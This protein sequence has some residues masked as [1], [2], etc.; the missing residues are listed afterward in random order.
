MKASQFFILL[1]FPLQIAF[2]QNLKPYTLALESSVSIS[3]LKVQIEANLELNGIQV[4]GQYQPADDSSRWVIV[5][6]SQEL[7]SAV[8]EVGGRTGFGAALRLGITVENGKTIVSYTN[9]EYWGKAYFR[10]EFEKVSVNYSTLSDNLQRAMEATG[11][12]VGTYFGSKKGLSTKELTKY[13]Y[14]L[15]MPRFG[16]SVRLEEFGSHQ[17]AIDKIESAIESGVP[18]VELVY[19]LDIPDQDLILYGFALSGDKG[20]GRFL[21]IIDFGNPKHTAFLPYEI[22]VIGDEVHMLHGRY[23][24]AISF[25]DLKMRTFSRIMSTPGDIE[26]LMRQLV[27]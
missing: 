5:F 22:L 21:P 23:R 10:E 19:K 18:N 4:I 17:E 26:K 16:N 1:L 2:G 27:K 20:E 8:N 6:S 14:M 24:I 9:P 13:R 7:L 11:M 15:G 3:E 25:P 12:Y